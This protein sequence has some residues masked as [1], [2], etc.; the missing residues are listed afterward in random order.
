MLLI[1]TL[2]GI[3]IGYIWAKYCRDEYGIYDPLYKAWFDY[4]EMDPEQLSRIIP[5][6]NKL[7]SPTDKSKKRPPFWKE[8][9]PIWLKILRFMVYGKKPKPYNI[10]R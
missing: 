9:S 10:K 4:S 1:I 7:C 2:L 8:K 6:T 3:L 5:G